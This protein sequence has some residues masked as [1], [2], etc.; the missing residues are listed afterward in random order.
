MS[1]DKSTVA[2]I[3]Q[4]A[5]I[6]VPEDDLDALADEL[7]KIVGWVEQL[8]E[9]DTEGVAPMASTAE[10]TV[11]RQRDDI[12]TDGDCRDDVLSNA[13]ETTNGY[14]VVPKVIE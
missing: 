7:S 13:P 2:R 8:D 10:G 9:V 4:L 12:V 11:L 3:A 1:V 14:F 5:R 6:K